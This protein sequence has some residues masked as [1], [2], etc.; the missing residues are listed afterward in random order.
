MDKNNANLKKLTKFN[1]T[2]RVKMFST[3]NHSR[4]KSQQAKIDLNVESE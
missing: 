1:K 4:L 2:V 3:E